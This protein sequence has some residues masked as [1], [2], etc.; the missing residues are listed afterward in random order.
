MTC[1]EYGMKVVG[2]CASYTKLYSQK[3]AEHHIILTEASEKEDVASTN[4]LIVADSGMPP[5]SDSR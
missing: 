3:D 5:I 2:E 1:K 4:D